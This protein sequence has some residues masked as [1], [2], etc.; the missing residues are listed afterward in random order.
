[1]TTTTTDNT[2]GMAE[3]VRQWFQGPEEEPETREWARNLTD[4]EALEIIKDEEMVTRKEIEE[5][6]GDYR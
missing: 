5:W 2:N 1:M 4:E 6:D 3:K